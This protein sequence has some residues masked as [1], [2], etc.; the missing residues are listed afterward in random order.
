MARR[1]L[2]LTAGTLLSI[3]TS[4]QTA[5]AI[6]PQQSPVTNNQA[7]LANVVADQTLNVVDVSDSTTQGVVSDGNTFTGSIIGSPLNVQSVQTM[8]GNASASGRVNVTTNYGAVTTIDV[9]ATGN[10]GT[11][12]VLGGGTLTGTATQTTGAV[13]ILALAE[14]NGAN[15][16]AGNLSN[17]AQAVANSHAYGLTDSAAT[18]ALTQSSAAITQSDA[19]L[20]LG[21]T[22]DTALITATSTSN[23]V[24]AEGIGT[25]SQTLTLTQSMTGARTQATVNAN[26]GNAQTI[27]GQA[28]TIGNNISVT[29]QGGPLNVV[30]DQTNAGYVQSQSVVTAY[31]FGT[32]QSTAYGVGNSVM[33][34]NQGQQLSLTNTQT[35]SGNGIEAQASFSSGAGGYDATASS[36]AIGNAVTGY[37]CSQCSGR[38]TVANRQT[39]S[40]DVGATSSATVSASNRSVTGT[41]AATGNAASFY[42]SSP[43]GN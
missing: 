27:L 43:S 8:S 42:V 36:I 11:S 2:I 23:N 34:G 39:N 26:A 5:A 25:S 33:V 1:A 22:A 18:A 19:G 21:Y 35:N 10:D 29:N 31:E 37:A 3:L 9:A 41:A 14:Y 24:T 30:T 20:T 28:S 4:P 15:A 32:A 12:N 17:S 7:Q 40:A 13:N 38:M 16:Q 6:S